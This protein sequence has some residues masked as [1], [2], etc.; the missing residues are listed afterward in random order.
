M[1]IVGLLIV[2][3]LFVYGLVRSACYPLI[4]RNIEIAGHLI[5]LKTMPLV[6]YPTFAEYVNFS[7][8]FFAADLPWLSKMLPD[9]FFNTL[10]SMPMG[11]LF[12]YKNMNFAAMQ[13]LSFTV[14]LVILIL[15]YYLLSQDK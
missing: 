7:L 14:F 10:D 11:Y 5:A 12:Y 8:G 2:G 3:L 1:Y 9:S 13:L 6:V 4:G 15:A